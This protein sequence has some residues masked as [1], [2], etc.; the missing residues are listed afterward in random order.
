MVLLQLSQLPRWVRKQRVPP[1]SMPKHGQKAS[2]KALSKTSKRQ[3]LK[4]P[5]SNLNQ[6]SST[7][8][9][10]FLPSEPSARVEGLATIE[11]PGK[12]ARTFGEA[13]SSLRSRRQQ[14]LTVV[15]DLGGNPEPLKP[16][17]FTH[18]TSSLVRL[19]AMMSLY[20]LLSIS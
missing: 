19:F 3:K 5:S 16:E 13:L 1:S 11:T 7:Q 8:F 18:T 14:V 12:P 9:Q 20:S 15:S 10:A 6:K 2:P 17:H 4:T